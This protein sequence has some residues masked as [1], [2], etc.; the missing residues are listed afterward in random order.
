MKEQYNNSN[1]TPLFLN[2]KFDFTSINRRFSL[3]FFATLTAFLFLNFFEP[4][5]IYHDGTTSKQDVFVE[6]FVAMSFVF[7]VMIFTQFV[8]RPFFKQYRNNIGG[9]VLWFLIE[10]VLCAN[11]WTFLTLFVKDAQNITTSALS[12]WGENFVAYLAVMF[13][14]YALFIFYINMKDKAKPNEI[15]QKDIE[16]KPKTV[17]IKDESGEIKLILDTD[18]LVYIQ[19][20]DNYIEINYLE[21][22]ILKKELIR[23]SLKNIEE[24]LNDSPI[25]RCHRSFMLNT[26]KIES[27]KKTTAGFEVKLRNISDTIIPVSR[28]YVSELKKYT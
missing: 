7:M 28:S 18:N 24:M 9:I 21:E 6:L 23:N 16:I 19:S 14:P 20:A 17:A 13:L 8:I 15:H 4:F 25:I 2:H 12:V 1:R 10:A 5:G 3:V 27:A 22:D 26:Q 11:I